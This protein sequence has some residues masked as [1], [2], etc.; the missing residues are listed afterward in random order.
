MAS[1]PESLG[2]DEGVEVGEQKPQLTP[3]RA[4]VEGFAGFLHSKEDEKLRADAADSPGRGRDERGGGFTNGSIEGGLLFL[5]LRQPAG[6]STADPSLLA[7]KQD[8]LQAVAAPARQDVLRDG[9]GIGSV[10]DRDAGRRWELNPRVVE[11]SEEPSFEAVAAP[12]RRLVFDE[13]CLEGNEQ[14][15]DGVRFRLAFGRMRQRAHG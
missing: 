15:G 12:E 5:R 9:V 10:T 11:F 6:S 3:G 7:T 8:L 14:V 4:I 2:L 1:Q 13:Q